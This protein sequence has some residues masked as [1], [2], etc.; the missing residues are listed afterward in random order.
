MLRL[1]LDVQRV[2]DGILATEDEF[3][4]LGYLDINGRWYGNKGGC[5]SF[6]ETIF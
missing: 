1:H 4:E 5:G 2:V 3:K 6:V